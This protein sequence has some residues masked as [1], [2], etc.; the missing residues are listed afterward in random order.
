MLGMGTLHFSKTL[1]GESFLPVK[2]LSVFHLHQLTCFHQTCLIAVESPS[3]LSEVLEAKS[4][5]GFWETDRYASTVTRAA[6]TWKCD[7]CATE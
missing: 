2:M 3:C 1:L 7:F 5:C 4:H 6:G